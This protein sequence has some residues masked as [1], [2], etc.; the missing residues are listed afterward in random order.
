VHV[1][2]RLAIDAHERGAER[3]AIARADVRREIRGQL[4]AE[5]KVEVEE[6]LEREVAEESAAL[7][8]RS[9]LLV[10]EGDAHYKFRHLTFQEFLAARW[11]ATQERDASRRLGEKLADPWWREVALLFLGF[12]A[13]DGPSRAIERLEALS[14]R[15]EEMEPAEQNRA[16]AVLARALID[17]RRY[18]DPERYRAPA[19]ALTATWQRI[20]EDPSQAAVLEDRAAIGDAL[21]LYGDPRLSAARRWI[22]VPRGRFFRGAATADKEADR[23]EKPSGWIELTRPYHIQRWA[24][25]AG[26]YAEFWSDGGYRDDRWWSKEGRAFRD[27]RSIAAPESWEA[28]RPFASRPVVGV[29][30]YEAAAY[31]KWLSARAAPAG[32]TIRLPTEAEWE[33]AARGGEGDERPERIY[34]WGD[35]WEDD[36]AA[37]MR[38]DLSH[39]VAVGLFPKGHGPGGIWDMSGNVWE[40]CLDGNTKRSLPEYAATATADPFH[41][42]NAVRVIR[43]GGFGGLPRSLRVSYRVGYD[44]GDRNDALGFRVVCSPGRPS[45]LDP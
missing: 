36:R 22:E 42:G 41:S 3:Q 30:W 38:S 5:K 13:K 35:R 32:E 44:P 34:P 16:A 9:G 25:T 10:Y 17:L 23:D 8:D 27:A 29:S 19:A 43:G 37:S 24:V 18:P 12:E 21:G 45:I 20:V 31:A 11:L 26:E 40:W 28:Q 2:S 39:A 1:F 6:V 14:K 33:R 7:V 4:A 15:T